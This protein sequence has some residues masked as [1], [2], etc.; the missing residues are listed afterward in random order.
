[1]KQHSVSTIEDVFLKL[2]RRDDHEQSIIEA[3]QCAPNNLLAAVTVSTTTLVSSCSNVN[4]SVTAPMDD[5]EVSYLIF[6]RIFNLMDIHCTVQQGE[7]D[8]CWSDQ[9]SSS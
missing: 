7:E 4:S 8:K 3:K 5:D 2:C 9:E 1:M 6:G